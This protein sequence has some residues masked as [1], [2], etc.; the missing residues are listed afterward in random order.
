MVQASFGIS[1]G[2]QLPPAAAGFGHP[3]TSTRGRVYLRCYLSTFLELAELNFR[4]KWEYNYY[5][6][7]RPFL[8]LLD[9]FLKALKVP[10]RGL[11]SSI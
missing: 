10:F 5:L 1:R 6:F 11:Q 3:P 4:A 7:I 8:M 9:Y 2:R